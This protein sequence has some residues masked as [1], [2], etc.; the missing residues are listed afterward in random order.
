M[1]KTFYFSLLS[2]FLFLISCKNKT[3]NTEEEVLKYED[4][5]II[6]INQDIE[7]EYDGD[8]AGYISMIEFFED[9]WEYRKGQPYTILKIKNDIDSS[10]VGLE[11]KLWEEMTAPFIKSDINAASFKGKYTFEK[12]EDPNAPL[13]FYDYIAKE[14]DLPVQKTT[15][16]L[17]KFSNRIRSV[18]IEGN[19]KTS[20]GATMEQKLLYVTGELFQIFQVTRKNGKEVNREK[21][22]YLFKF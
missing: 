2:G 17:D 18:Y 1:K 21:V 13:L 10:Y 4:L 19:F 12:I 15:V 3:E 8:D 9:Q 22:N 11:E 7:L 5:D 20:D 16:S 6:E 14:S